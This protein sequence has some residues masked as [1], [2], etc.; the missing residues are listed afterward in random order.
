MLSPSELACCFGLTES[1][2]R[3]LREMEARCQNCEDKSSEMTTMKNLYQ[4]LGE[5]LAQPMCQDL[6]G[7]VMESMEGKVR[8]KP[9]SWPVKVEQWDVGGGAN[10]HV[11]SFPTLQKRQWDDEPV[12]QPAHELLNAMNAVEVRESGVGGWGV[13]ASR[14]LSRCEVVTMYEGCRIWDSETLHIRA[15]MQ[16]RGDVN[17][18]K[19]RDWLTHVISR[20]R[21]GVLIQGLREPV[22]GHGVASLV[23]ASRDNANAEFV[24]DPNGQQIGLKVTTGVQC[25]WEL[26]V[27]YHTQD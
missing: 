20:E 10:V 24:V 7:G 13:F 5:S 8:H 26:F 6:L 18:P 2:V 12:V 14:D 9:C 22:E 17:N 19:E 27:D 1:R 25:G 3:V 21:G 23:N 11:V 4:A 16:C 15:Q